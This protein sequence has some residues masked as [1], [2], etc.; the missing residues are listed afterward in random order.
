MRRTHPGRTEAWQG[1]V[2][3]GKLS[4][5]G[6]IAV[7]YDISQELFNCDVF[8]GDPAPRMERLQSIAAGDMCNL[9]AVS[10][11]AH[12]GTH[13]DAP[14]H[15][16]RDGRTIDELPPD[17]F[18]GPAWVAAHTGGVSAADAESICRAADA[19]G[20]GE[21]IL[22]KGA[23]T[24]TADA[25]RVFAR[26]G[27]KLLGNESQTVGPADAPAEVHRILL[28]AETVLLEGIRLGAVPPGRYTLC[29]VPLN[30]GG[31]D[32]SPCRAVLIDG[33]SLT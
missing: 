14:F 30:L 8:P 22:L 27:L 4:A 1:G 5:K 6:G 23:L 15:F 13:V 11:C 19:A 29:A 9:T 12:N 2:K 24:V 16:L 33:E 18:I 20:A 28:G 25:A 21:R 26:R 3:R 10:L 17:V 31:C 32:G 7:I